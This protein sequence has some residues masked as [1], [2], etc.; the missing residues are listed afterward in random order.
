MEIP[1]TSTGKGTLLRNAKQ[2][3]TK[4]NDLMVKMA[5]GMQQQMNHHHK[6]CSS[7]SS[8]NDVQNCSKQCL[9][10]FKILQKNF[11]RER[12]KH[13]RARLEIQGYELALES[14]ESRILGH[15][16]NEM[17]WDENEFQNYELKCREVKID[18]LKMELEK[19]VKGRDEL[20]VKIEK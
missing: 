8:D 20:K 19:V 13:S 5:G 14:I 18:N 16:K 2:E 12:E 3:G 7:S 4:G 11:D 1:T 10:S 17:A 15:E 9:E 6:H